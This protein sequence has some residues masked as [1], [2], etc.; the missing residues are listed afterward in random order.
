MN[1]IPDRLIKSAFSGRNTFASH[2]LSLVVM[3]FWATLVQGMTITRTSCRVESGAAQIGETS[4]FSW[5]LESNRRGD[6]Q[7]AYRILVNGLWDSGKVVSDQSVNVAYAGPP[8]IPGKN[9]EWK[10][11]VW[12]K[13]GRPSSWSRPTGWQN[14]LSS[15]EAWQAKWIGATGRPSEALNQKDVLLPT[16]G[17]GFAAIMSQRS[18][19]QRSHSPGNRLCL[20]T[21]TL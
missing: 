14:G 5:V 12:D 9:Y 1:Q 3:L 20:R 4:T 13:A 18:G 11:K 10:L 21:W 17:P 16:N 15:D 6:A 7:T 8:P 19:N 2:R